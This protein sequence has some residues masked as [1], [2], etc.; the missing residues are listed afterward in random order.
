M[1]IMNRRKAF[2]LLGLGL[3]AGVGLALTKVFWKDKAK[4][5]VKYTLD[6]LKPSFR[7]PPEGKE[8]SVEQALNSRCTSDYD[9]DS[10]KFHWGKFDRWKKLTNAQAED[11]MSLA[12]IPRF[13]K[14]ILKTKRENNVLTFI[15]GKS[16]VGV[17]NDWAMVE[18]GMQQQAVCLVCAALGVGMVFSNLG[19]DGKWI[20][21]TEYAAINMKL[22]AME[23]S[24]EGS[25]WTSFPPADKNPWQRGNLPDPVR[26]G[27]KPLISILTNLK[28]ENKGSVTATEQSISQL[29]WAGRGRTPHL[30]KSKPWGM[31]IPT[32]AGEQ[33]I[34]SLYLVS[35]NKLFSYVNWNDNRPTHSLLQLNTIEAGEFKDILESFSAARALIVIS[36]NELFARALW[37]VGYQLMNMLVQAASLEI[38]YGSFLFNEREKEK[39]AKIGISDPVTALAL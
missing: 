22:G 6:R 2:K 23:A 5:K 21:D 30:Y 20:S 24:Y 37:E 9:G 31:T 4:E 26:D 39:L 11:V 18:V 32:W 19:K 10:G 38:S 35:E 13:T 28:T 1:L 12:R 25:Y 14:G 17:P 34:S 15:F 16:M 7:L 29:L 33:N 3:A 36:K 27:H 8:V